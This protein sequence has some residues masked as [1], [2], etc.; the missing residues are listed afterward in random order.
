[1]T[2]EQKPR[3]VSLIASSTEIIHAL[4]LGQY[5]VGR[6]H[7]CDFPESVKSLPVCTSPKFQIDGSSYEIDQRVKAILQESLSVYKVDAN[8]LE[9][10]QPSHRI[11][12]G[13]LHCAVVGPLPYSFR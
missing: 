10:L 1:M 2:A 9:S 5:M 3:I 11:F 8:I 6:S 7:E 12:G 13:M 4:G